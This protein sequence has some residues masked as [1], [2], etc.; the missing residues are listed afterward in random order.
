MTKQTITKGV[1][2]IQDGV[3]TLFKIA[4]VAIPAA[5]ATKLGI[6]EMTQQELTAVVAAL[7]ALF[8]GII[9]LKRR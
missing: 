6:T 1:K 3:V 8:F 7:I 9:W 2:E 5:T 4:T